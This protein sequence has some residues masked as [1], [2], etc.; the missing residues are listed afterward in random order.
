MGIL[1]L[2]RLEMYWQ[3]S[4]PYITTK[5]ISD[6]MT[7]TKFEQ[8]YRF[9]HLANNDDRPR[10]DNPENRDKLFNIRKLADLLLA[11]FQRNYVPHQTIKIDEAMIPFKGHLSFKQHMKDKPTKLG[12]KVFILSDATN[13][14]VYR[15]QIYAGKGMNRNVEVGLC[16]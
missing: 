4:N 13:G 14:Y 7:K 15:F 9:L 3:Q 6:V 10:D 12:I 5:G 1:R 8:I 16:S 2:P 11:S